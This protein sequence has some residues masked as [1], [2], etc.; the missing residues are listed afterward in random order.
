MKKTYPGF[1]FR[2]YSYN[3]TIHTLASKLREDYHDFDSGDTDIVLIL[4]E[5][6]ECNEKRMLLSERF[7]DRILVFDFDPHHNK[8]D[9]ETVKRMLAYYVDSSDMGK[10]YINYPMMQSYRHLKS[11]SDTDFLERVASPIDYK[12]TVSKESRI[13]DIKQYGFDAY[14]KIAAL[15]ATKVWY[16]LTGQNK[17]PSRENYL[18]IGWKELYSKILDYYLATSKSQVLNT[19]IFSLIDYNSKVYF[20]NLFK[21]QDKFLF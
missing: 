17:H 7:S 18:S 14:M 9:F 20:E 2:I 12:E 15:N 16:I 21:H 6:E 19:L 3:T 5:M 1:R 13:G 10:L 4:K 8:T 11:L